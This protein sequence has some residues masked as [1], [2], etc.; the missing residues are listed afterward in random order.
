MKVVWKLPSVIHRMK[1]MLSPTPD[2][3]RSKPAKVSEGR[4]VLRALGLGRHGTK[5]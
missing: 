4:D 3:L 2:T 1:A 5:H